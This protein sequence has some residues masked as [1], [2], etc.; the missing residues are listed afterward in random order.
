MSNGWLCHKFKA[1]L[2][3]AEPL[4]HIRSMPPALSSHK[5][6]AAQAYCRGLTFRFTNRRQGNCLRLANAGLNVP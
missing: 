1:F 3:S 2:V 6:W 4:L 5:G